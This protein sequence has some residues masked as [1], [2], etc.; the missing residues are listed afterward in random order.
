MPD[1]PSLDEQIASAERA[2]SDPDFTARYHAGLDLDRLNAQKLQQAIVKADEETRRR[3]GWPA[4]AG[5]PEPEPE[6][7]T[8]PLGSLDGGTR[9]VIPDPKGDLDRQLATAAQRGDWDLVDAL[10]AQKLAHAFERQ[11]TRDRL[12]AAPALGL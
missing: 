7:E 9:G 11:R 10:N 6:P 1:S 2:L 3:A 12:G 8:P 4:P 5:P